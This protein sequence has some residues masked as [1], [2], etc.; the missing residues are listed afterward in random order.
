MTP[1]NHPVPPP[2]RQVKLPDGSYQM[3]LLPGDGK[4]LEWCWGND[5]D[6][7]VIGEPFAFELE[8]GIVESTTPSGHEWCLWQLHATDADPTMYG[9]NPFLLLLVKDGIG[10]IRLLHEFSTPYNKSQAKVVVLASNIRFEPGKMYRW[11]LEGIVGKTGSV[12]IR[13][14]GL[15]LAD[16]AGPFGYEMNGNPYWNAG[17]YKWAPFEWIGRIV[18]KINFH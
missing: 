8:A 11:T 6:R 16:Y 18:V 2:D 5:K 9:A 4:R 3:T 17:I 14:D 12:R 15:L 1:Y 13:R 10:E 7:P